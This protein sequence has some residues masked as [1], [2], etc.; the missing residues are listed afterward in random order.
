MTAEE[1]LRKVLK[2]LYAHDGKELPEQCAEQAI[3]YMNGKSEAPPDIQ[4]R[5]LKGGTYKIKGYYMEND[6]LQDIRGASTL[7]SEVQNTLLP[8][9][10]R[11]LIGFDSIL[12]HGGGNL[13][14]LLPA[15]VSE[16]IAQELEKTADS[17]LITANSAYD[18]SEP[19]SLIDFL[20]EKYNTKTAELENKLNER[21]KMKLVFDPKPETAFLGQT[22]LDGQ[23]TA[24]L[25]SGKSTY[26]QKCKKRL[27][28]YTRKEKALCGGC[29][30][31]VY[32]GE[33]QKLRYLLDYAKQTG[34]QVKPPA[35]FKD[36]GREHI[37]FFYAD[38]NNMGG[39]IQR[40]HNIAE[41]IGFSDFVKDTIPQIV[42]ES[43]AECRIDSPE[44]VALGGDDIFLII[45]AEK[46]VAFA[47]KLIEKYKKV[48]SKQFPDSE[49][50]LSV[51]F[52]I[53]KPNTPIKVALEVAEEELDAAKQLVRANNDEDG[54]L[55]FRVL[56]TYEGAVSKRGKETL[57]PYSLTAAKKLL[58]YTAFLRRIQDINTIKT[59]L[60]NLNQAFHDAAC[61]EE[62]NLFLEYTNAKERELNKRLTLPD[63]DGYKLSDGYYSRSGPYL[64]E[65]EGYLWNDL[66]YLLEFGKRGDET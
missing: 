46:S 53:V 65:N 36:I 50:T 25:N 8:N 49:S 26:C 55:S 51:G 28:G 43:L 12:Y 27:A 23:L 10:L 30:H 38:G 18:L 60:Q 62:A 20:G 42:Y 57:I 3:Q 13:F 61:R 1:K 58:D 34:I 54:S 15:D 48:F 32:A 14:A 2:E 5:A 66:L 37:A 7:I 22:L 59:R 45:P 24:S 6:E 44:I 63:L 29:L 9:C 31:K 19:F 33:S 17:V 40:F 4:V 56:Q 47:V 11:K 16:D 35:V 41:M 21:K 52:S 64:K 39:I